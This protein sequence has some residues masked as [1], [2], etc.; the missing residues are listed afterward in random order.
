[1]AITKNEMSQRV[2]AVEKLLERGH[3]RQELIQYSSEKWEI[4]ERQTDE[5][6]RLATNNIAERTKEDRQ[7]QIGMAIKRYIGLYSK[8]FKDNKLQIALNAQKALCELLGLNKPAKFAP[9]DPDGEKSLGVVMVPYLN[10]GNGDDGNGD[11]KK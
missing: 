5:Y 2:Y 4:G 1:M 9:T 7:Y 3:C 11:D 10:G 8:A 6:I